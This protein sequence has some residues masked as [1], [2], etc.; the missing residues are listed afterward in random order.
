MT[1][2]EQDNEL[3][4]L[5]HIIQNADTTYDAMKL[6]TDWH[7]KQVEEMLDRLEAQWGET[8]DNTLG[9]PIRWEPTQ[10]LTGVN[11]MS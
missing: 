9:K 3:R 5:V 11:E 8:I 6:I 7:N 10:S 1:P 2:T 4:E